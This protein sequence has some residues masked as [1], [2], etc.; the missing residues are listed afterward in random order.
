MNNGRA[1]HTSC[2]APS[3]HKK[4]VTMSYK[5]KKFNEPIPKDYQNLYAEIEL[6][7]L[8]KN[9]DNGSEFLKGTNQSLILQTEPSNQYDR[10]AIAIYGNFTKKNLLLFSSEKSCKLGYLPKE[11]A[12]DIKTNNLIG[13]IKIRLRY[14]GI[15][16]KGGKITL[17]LLIPKTLMKKLKQQQKAE[18]E[19]LPI[20]KEQK[21]MLEFYKQKVPRGTTQI[22]ANA[23]ISS[24][25]QNEQDEW[26][27]LMNLYEDIIDKEEMKDYKIKKISL[28]LFLNIINDCK[29]KNENI[30]EL[31]PYEVYDYAL[32]KKPDLARK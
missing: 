3:I 8:F 4:E 27:M 10:N 14:I 2:A 21:N 28:T 7:G 31:D 22:Q 29:N 19:L 5:D 13:T 17:G 6:A 20:N 30:E 1:E 16:D 26:D 15:G 24:L 32:I 11:I 12:K 18:A 9:L 23:I 25:T